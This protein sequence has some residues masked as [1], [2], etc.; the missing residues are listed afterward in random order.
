MSAL[1]IGWPLGALLV[2]AALVACGAAEGN[3]TEDKNAYVERINA[4]QRTYAMTVTNV[5]KSVTPTST[6]RQD[7]RTIERFQTAIAE[8]LETLRTIKVPSDVR[9][10]HGQLVAVF[11]RLDKDI[12]L[13][14]KTLRERTVQAVA[15]AQRLLGAATVTVNTKLATARQAINRRLR[16]T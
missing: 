9:K 14:A 7:R 8:I 4:A 10:E 2:S 16:A 3:S 1:R 12:A 5:K 11:T 15:E 6:P 13:A